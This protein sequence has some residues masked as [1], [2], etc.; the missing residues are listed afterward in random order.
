MFQ[1]SDTNCKLEVG[2]HVMSMLMHCHFYPLNITW[3]SCQNSSPLAHPWLIFKAFRWKSTFGSSTSAKH[4]EIWFQFLLSSVNPG[5]KQ[6]PVRSWY[7]KHN[8]ERNT[9]SISVITNETFMD[10]SGMKCCKLWSS[11]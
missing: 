1:F 9:S 8:I 5:V 7:K 6:S 4:L 11:N 3:N 10:L 2:Y